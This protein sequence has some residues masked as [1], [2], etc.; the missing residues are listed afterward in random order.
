MNALMTNWEHCLG[1]GHSQLLLLFV[2]EPPDGLQVV[3]EAG[4]VV[5]DV[6]ALIVVRLAAQGPQL[7]QLQL[8]G[9]HL[10]TQPTTTDTWQC[11]VWQGHKLVVE[12]L[13]NKLKSLNL[14]FSTALSYLYD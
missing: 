5:V 2:E 11:S 9:L 6:V 12:E 8:L 3:G 4:I 7:S 13:M 14:F 1:D 10:V